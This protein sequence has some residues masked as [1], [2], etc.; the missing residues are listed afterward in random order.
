MFSART[1]SEEVLRGKVL[2]GKK[3]A[4]RRLKALTELSQSG[5]R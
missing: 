3:Q 2:D 1:H 5:A 4:I